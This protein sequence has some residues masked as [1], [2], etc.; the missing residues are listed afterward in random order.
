MGGWGEVHG[1]CVEG[2]LIS[3]RSRLS[4]SLACKHGLISMQSLIS[5]R[6]RLSSWWTTLSAVA[7]ASAADSEARAC[8]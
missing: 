2:P 5:R 8:H 7:A 1:R 3:R 6:S 4:S